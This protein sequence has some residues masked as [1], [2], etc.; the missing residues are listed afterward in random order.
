MNLS[1]LVPT[2]LVGPTGPAGTNATVRGMAAQL[3]LDPDQ[4]LAP[5]PYL[6]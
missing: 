1:T 4:V 2:G 3:G 5:D 6:T